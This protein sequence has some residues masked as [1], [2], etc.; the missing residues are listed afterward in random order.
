MVMILKD[1]QISSEETY[2]KIIQTINKKNVPPDVILMLRLYYEGHI[3][4]E[5]LIILG[6]NE[7]S[8]KDDIKSSLRKSDEIGLELVVDFKSSRFTGIQDLLKL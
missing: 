2:K 8:K 1:I 5:E 3:T 4:K 7:R 6:F